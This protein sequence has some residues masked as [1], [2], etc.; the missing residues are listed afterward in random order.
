MKTSAK[1]FCWGAN[2]S[3]QAS[4][5]GSKFSALSAGGSHT[6][7]VQPNGDSSCWGSNA[8]GQS[9]PPDSFG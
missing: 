8:S 3:G 2:S 6:C 7:A 4:V 9:D 1:V 5:F